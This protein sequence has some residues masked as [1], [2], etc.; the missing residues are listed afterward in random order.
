[1][2]HLRVTEYDAIERAIVDG[3]RLAVRRRGSE[4]VV[5]PEQLLIKDGRESIVARHPTTG[6]RMVIHLDEMDGVEAVR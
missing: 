6:A 3:S 2:G 4:F 5:V 1:M